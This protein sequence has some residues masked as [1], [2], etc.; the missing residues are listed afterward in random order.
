MRIENRNEERKRE[1]EEQRERGQRR[2]EDAYLTIEQSMPGAGSDVALDQLFCFIKVIAP[3][4]V[5]TFR[6][7]FIDLGHVDG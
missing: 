4:Q 5:N 1:K 6:Y 2:E 3:Q 7:I